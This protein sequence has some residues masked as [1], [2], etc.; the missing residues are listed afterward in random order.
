[1]KELITRANAKRN[2]QGG[3]C[4][5]NIPP[6]DDDDDDDEDG[7]DGG[8]EASGNAG[9]AGGSNSGNTGIQS[10]NEGNEETPSQEKKDAGAADEEESRILEALE[11]SILRCAIDCINAE[12]DA[13][14]KASI[15]GG[16]DNYKMI[17]NYLELS[18]CSVL[19]GTRS[20]LL[21]ISSPRSF[22]WTRNAISLIDSHDVG[23]SSNNS[24]HGEGGITSEKTTY[25]DWD[26]II[27]RNTGIWDEVSFSVTG[28][29]A[30]S[31]NRLTT[32][33]GFP[34]IPATELKF[35][36]LL[37]S[38]KVHSTSSSSC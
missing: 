34:H 1:M 17:V 31:K 11:A 8:G 7:E 33:K 28:V 2:D 4:F 3:S 22:S 21:T 16:S 30:A 12:K 26:C 23:H 24:V 35:I 5:Y 36:T 13:V 9:N 10:Q 19:Q 20:S 32:L 29:L 27:E 38:R 14:T 18:I 6:H 15:R 25:F 37:C